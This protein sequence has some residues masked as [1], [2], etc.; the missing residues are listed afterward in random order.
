MISFLVLCQFLTEYFVPVFS[1]SPQQYHFF[2]FAISE[3]DFSLCTHKYIN[4]GYTL[5][6]TGY[7]IVV[8]CTRFWLRD[9]DWSP[10]ITPGLKLRLCSNGH[11][12]FNFSSTFL[13][14]FPRHFMLHKMNHVWLRL[15]QHHR[16]PSSR[17]HVE[18][19]RPEPL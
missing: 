11:V 5:S 18:V 8:V 2:F 17:R 19:R 6:E 1:H 15:R 4:C 3:F 12:A 10:H 13:H 9:C 16:S 14:V 7:F